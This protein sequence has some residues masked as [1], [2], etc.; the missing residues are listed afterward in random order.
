[1]YLNLPVGHLHGWGICGKWLSRELAGLR[2]VQLITKPFTLTDAGDVESYRIL[3]R[4]CVEALKTPVSGERIELP[5]SLFQS[6][7]DETLAPYRP[8]LKARLQVGYTF[9][10][11]NILCP[12]WIENGRRFDRVVTGSTWCADVLLAHGLTTVNTVI[13]GTDPTVFKPAP[14]ERGFDPHKF[15]IFSGGKFEL[16]KSQDIVIRAFKVMQ[17]SYKDVLLVVS[18]FNPWPQTMNTMCESTLIKFQMGDKIQ[19]D[20]FLRILVDN[21]IKPENVICLP[22][23]PPQRMAKIYRSTD[24]GLFP[25]RCEGGSNLVLME[26]MACGKP[27]IATFSTGQRDVLRDGNALLIHTNREKT[28]S[29][30][31]TPVAQWPEP[32]LDDV[33]EKLRWAYENRTKLHSLGV[34]AAMDL[35]QCTWRASAEKINAIIAGMESALD[36]NADSL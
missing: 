23:Q 13:Q 11:R 9:F 12:R 8:D 14:A 35:S 3:R 17:E 19:T 34:A 29:F 21:G 27:V 24:V 25:N 36:Q 33:I 32:D 5:G 16:R 31:G 22:P 15:V 1:M 6:I 4:L 7:C 2:P 20:M 10:E 18:W 28:Y 26:Y 30:A